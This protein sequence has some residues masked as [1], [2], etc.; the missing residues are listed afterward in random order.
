MALKPMHEYY[1]SYDLYGMM[2]NIRRC[3]KL[4]RS[5]LDCRK[6]IKNE[7]IAANYC[8]NKL[9]LWQK[10]CAD[11]R[12]Q[13]AASTAQMPTSSAPASMAEKPVR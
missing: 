2:G 7:N 8:L 9:T 10:H 5:Y 12:E 13:T 11:A 1:A 6:G 4:K 3:S